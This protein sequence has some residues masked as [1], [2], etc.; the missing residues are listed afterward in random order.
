MKSGVQLYLKESWIK[1]IIVSVLIHGAVF[2]VPFPFMV[3]RI[4][5]PI[6]VFTLEG[7]GVASPF[8]GGEKQDSSRDMPRRAMQ[9]PTAKEEV[10]IRPQEP[11]RPVEQKAEPAQAETGDITATE[12]IARKNLAGVTQIKAG[13]TIGVGRGKTVSTAGGSG[14]VVTSASG[15]VTGVSAA[16]AGFGSPDGPRFLHRE[17]PDYPFMAKK[18]KK[19]GKVVLAV[20]IDT[21]GRLTKAEVV[22]ASDKVFIETSLEA[23]KKSTF[24]PAKR[25]GRPVTSRALLPIRFSLIE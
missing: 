17:I 12:L 22:E 13:T 5:E 24:L 21:T 18:R 2:S 8:G 23:L 3:P 14:T 11:S 25:N 7:T 6:E 19:E 20:V 4:V 1:Y 15:Q 9:R 16:E 10:R